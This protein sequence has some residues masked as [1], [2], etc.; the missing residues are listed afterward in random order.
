MHVVDAEGIGYHLGAAAV[1]ARQQVAADM[2]LAQGCDGL[3]GT[4]LDAVAEGKQPQHARLCASFNQPGQGTAFGFPGLCFCGEGAGLQVA[5]VEQAPV[6]QRQFAAFHPASD[7]TAGKGLAVHYR[8][9]LQAL[10]GASVEYR[11]GQG[12]FAATLQGPRQAVQLGTITD[13]GLAVDN[14]RA[15]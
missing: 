5:L 8:G 13:Q 6:A 15:A 12:V 14:A 7:A 2:A 11:L 10:L 3:F 9:N 4:G 1:V